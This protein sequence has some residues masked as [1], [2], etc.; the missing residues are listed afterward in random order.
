MTLYA[1]DSTIQGAIAVS[2]N[3]D[4]VDEGDKS[5]APFPGPEQGAQAA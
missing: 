5:E 3:G 4:F 1:S 2:G